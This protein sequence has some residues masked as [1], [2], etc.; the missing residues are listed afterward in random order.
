MYEL[1]FRPNP[2]SKRQKKKKGRAILS[3]AQGTRYPVVTLHGPGWACV[4]VGGGGCISLD[5]IYH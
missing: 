2:A 5:E 4:N 3:F 1:T